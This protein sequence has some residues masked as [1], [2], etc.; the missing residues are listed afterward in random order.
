VASIGSISFEFDDGP[1]R[2]AVGFWLDKKAS[3]NTDYRVDDNWTVSIRSGEDAIVAKSKMIL[4][5]NDAYVAARGTI[6]RALDLI[7][8]GL[9]EPLLLKSPNDD[10]L[11]VDTRGSKRTLTYRTRSPCPIRVAPLQ[12]AVRD[13]DG[14][15]ISPKLI[16]PV[17]RPVLHYYRLSQ[18]RD[19]M[20]D[21][22]RYM[23][24]AFEALLQSQCPIRQRPK[25]NEVGWL[26]RALGQLA[27]QINLE[28][29]LPPSEADP[30][31][32]FV[33]D[34]YT[35]LRLPLF[36]AKKS[37]DTLPH[38]GLLE[39]D[40]TPAYSSITTLVRHALNEMLQYRGQSGQVSNFL[41]QAG[42]DTL[43]AKKGLIA[44]F[45]ADNTPVMSGDEV[46][47]PRGDPIVEFDTLG[48]EPRS[49]KQNR[50]IM[51]SVSVTERISKN[52]VHRLGLVAEDKVLILGGI[53]NPLLLDQ[54]GTFRFE[55]EFSLINRNMPRWT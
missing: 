55:L 41:F 20:F 17:W 12:I 50:L 33:E 40:L 38:E 27:N 35:K 37:A 14:R 30:I 24:L 11:V 44:A 49:N 18:T 54:I 9:N 46:L 22:Y 5:S 43:L 26:K 52:P 21:A 45:T 3:L 7:C 36:H 28:A 10:H 47:S 15:E 8:F 1:S 53:E 6:D 29:L 23:F 51:A 32:A 2:T 34:Q 42:I 48:A 25:E 31:G 13:A 19:N 16:R 39:E 4:N